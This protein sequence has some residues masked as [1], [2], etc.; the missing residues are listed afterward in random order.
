ML[1]VNEG[2]LA[3]IPRHGWCAPHLSHELLRRADEWLTSVEEAMEAIQSAVV[4]N[5]AQILSETNIDVQEAWIN[6]LGDMSKHGTV[7]LPASSG[8]S[9]LSTMP[10]QLRS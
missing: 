6:L 10:F 4:S 3:G 8:G 5:S 1:G 9:S 7:H 2:N